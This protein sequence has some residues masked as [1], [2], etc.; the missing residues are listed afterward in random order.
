[1][2]T[3]AKHPIDPF[4]FEWRVPAHGF[5]WVQAFV[6]PEKPGEENL[7][8]EPQWILVVKERGG[9]KRS[10]YRPLSNFKFLG[11]FRDFAEVE[12]SREG[13]L[14]FANKYGALGITRSGYLNHPFVPDFEGET[15]FDWAVQIERLRQAIEVWDMLRKGDQKGLRRLFHWGHRDRPGGVPKSGPNCWFYRSHSQNETPNVEPGRIP[16]W[17]GERT[18]HMMA[19]PGLCREGDIVALARIFLGK[20]ITQALN[21]VASPLMHYA[22]ESQRLNLQIVPA[23]LLAAMWLQFARAIDTDKQYRRCKACSRW[24]QVSAGDSRTDRIF[25]SDPCKSRDYRAKK[26]E[27]IRLRGEKRTAQQIAKRLGTTPEVVKRWLK[28]GNAN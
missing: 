27:A 20:W 10:P 23:T 8:H 22:K 21:G 6:P 7:P 26:Q 19:I 9:L 11:L 28:E 24:F 4:D 17:P 25:C 13:I 1:M 14:Q 2:N 3:S 5:Q 16:A 12:L 15:L 18:D